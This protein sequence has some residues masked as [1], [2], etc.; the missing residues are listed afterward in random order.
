[1][2]SYTFVSPL[3]IRFYF[4]QFTMFDTETEAIEIG[5]ET[6]TPAPLILP[7]SS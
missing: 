5:P 4:D 1:M 3:N 6:E 2:I 7:L